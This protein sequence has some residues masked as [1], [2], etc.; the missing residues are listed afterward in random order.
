MNSREMEWERLC[1]NLSAPR[2][3]ARWRHTANLVD[4]T[5]IVIFGGYHSTHERLNDVWVSEREQ[6]FLVEGMPFLV[7]GI[8]R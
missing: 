6:A 7:H 2:P 1:L 3:P 4:L 5:K 8:L